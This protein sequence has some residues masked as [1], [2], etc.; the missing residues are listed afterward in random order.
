MNDSN[1]SLR[2]S[3]SYREAT[4]KLL[5]RS[6]FSEPEPIVTGKEVLFWIVMSSII[7]AVVYFIKG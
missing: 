6:D 7:C 3:R 4:G 2:F 5:H 1:Y